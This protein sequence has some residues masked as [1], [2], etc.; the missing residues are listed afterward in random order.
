VTVIHLVLPEGVDDPAHPSGGNVYDRH[1]SRALTELGWCVREHLTS[2]DRLNAVLGTPPDGSL[3]LVDGLLAGGPPDMMARA[4]ARLRLVVLVHMPWDT[5]GERA[6][7]R[8]CAAVLTTSRWTRQWLLD[9]Y[10]LPERRVHVAEPGVAAAALTMG[11]GSGERL[12]CVS[13][14]TRGKGHDVL[15]GALG[16]LRHL[17]WACRCVGA[18]DLDPAFVDDVARRSEELSVVDR[19]ALVGPRSSGELEA[20]YAAADLLVLASRA[21]TYAMVV[22]EALA[23]GVP[24]VATS[25]GG[26]PDALGFAADGT[27]PGVLVP[28]E[29]GA[30]LRVAL[31]R[32]LVDES[33]RQRLRDAARSRRST[34]SDWAGTGQRVARVLANLCQRDP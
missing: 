5:E 13:A 26:V 29:D 22:T 25:V 11:S 9:R 6:T 27:R 24:V 34:L 16:G 33:L 31:E 3:V 7:L 20:E 4:A 19:L 32:W 21:E 10:Q 2:R 28:P 15:I 30:A 14:V 8:A 1:L 23:R 12:L 17:S 18:L